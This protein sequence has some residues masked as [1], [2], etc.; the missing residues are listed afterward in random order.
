MAVPSGLL[1]PTV[2][3]RMSATLDRLSN[4]RLLV[5]VVTGGDPVEN[6]GDGLLLPHGE[7]YE[8]TREFMKVYGALLE[9]ETV[10][11]KGKHVKSRM[12]AFSIRPFN[13]R[14]HRSTSA[15]PPMPEST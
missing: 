13:R 3:A 12:P 4:G 5:N 15:D 10:T 14:C 1:S 2:A 11:F 6:R 8:L 9:G 7:R